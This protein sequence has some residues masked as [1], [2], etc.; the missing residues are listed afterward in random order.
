M[1][2]VTVERV[3]QA[4]EA[5]GAPLMTDDWIN[6]SG[7]DGY[8]ACPLSQCAAFECKL[9]L[10]DLYERI[11]HSEEPYELIGELLGLE[12]CYVQ[13]FTALFDDE[14]A[15]SASFAISARRVRRI[16]AEQQYRK[17]LQG[18]EDGLAVRWAFP[19]NEEAS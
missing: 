9:E 13:G 8:Q 4:H 1:R 5:L 18:A 15:S 6:W 16:Y 11:S 7:G 3:R 14:N 19:S 12:Y 2:R 17:W 10:R